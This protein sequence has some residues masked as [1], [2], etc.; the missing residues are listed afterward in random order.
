M[1]LEQVKEILEA[2]FIVGEEKMDLEVKMACGADLLSDVLAF[3]K[4]GSLLLSGLTNQQIIYT[5]E[6]AE[7]KAIC[8]VRSKRPPAETI[9]LAK[10]SN[11]TLLCTS[12]YFRENQGR[13]AE[14]LIPQ[15][16]HKKRLPA[17]L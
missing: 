10:K 12:T 13:A 15:N 1:L 4:P 16:R 5:A 8:F 6:I 2:E 14:R 9:E 11:I 7:L 3:T 17:G